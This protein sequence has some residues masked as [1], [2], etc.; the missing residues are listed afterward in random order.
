MRLWDT[1]L[2]TFQQTQQQFRAGFL[3]FGL[4]PEVRG[5]AKIP[6]NEGGS[7]YSGNQHWRGLV[8]GALVGPLIKKLKYIIFA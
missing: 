6:V 7:K 5:G 2:E 8:M 3:N 1:I 4:Q